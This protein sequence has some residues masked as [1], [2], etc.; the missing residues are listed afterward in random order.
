MATN[1]GRWHGTLILIGQPAEETGEGA[2]A[3]LKDGLLT[4]FPRPDFALAIHDSPNQPA[5]QVGYTPGY[6][7]AAAESVDIMIFG[8]GGHGGRPQN[9]IDPVV[10]AAR[11]VLALQ[12]IV[13]RENNPGLVNDRF[14]GNSP[15]RSPRP[16]HS[17]SG[18]NARLDDGGSCCFAGCGLGGI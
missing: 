12:T 7:H 9:T 1:R 17:D 5:G 4:R 6:S 3:M 16:D 11:T 10:I 8:V 15:V 2:A 18:S 14:A 13:S